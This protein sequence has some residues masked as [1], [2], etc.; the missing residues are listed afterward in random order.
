MRVNHVSRYVDHFSTPFDSAIHILTNSQELYLTCAEPGVLPWPAFFEARLKS[1]QETMTS[2]T[3]AQHR[4]DKA[5]DQEK[6]S[7]R[8]S[9]TGYDS[10]EKFFASGW[11]NP[12]RPQYGIPGWQR[13]TFMKH[14]DNLAYANLDDLWAHEGI[15]L[16]G[17]RIIVGRWWYASDDPGADTYGDNS[18]PFMLWAVD[19]LNYRFD[20][21]DVDAKDE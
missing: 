4:Q 16:P 15:V 7:I 3:R 12:L 21:E 20:E 10:E 18:G 11:I 6:A 8:F 13:I 17:G 9:G 2:F 14:Y 19:E 5:T 1:L